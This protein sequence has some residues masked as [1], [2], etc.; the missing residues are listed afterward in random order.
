VILIDSNILID[1]FDDDQ[2]WRDWS[3][4]QLVALAG[5]RPLAVNQ[6]AYAEVA[7]R[8][9]TIGMFQAALDTF[10]IGY[11]PFAEDAAFLAGQV[12]QSYRAR[13]SSMGSVL[14][15]FFIGG[16]A[17]VGGATVLTRDTR[18]YRTYFPTVPLI[19]PDRAEP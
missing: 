17:Q 11:E 4:E 13:R 15:D 2:D 19:T 6:I 7:P 5:E 12:F 10:E 16:H 14:P 1:V 18:L 8:M 3:I 9:G